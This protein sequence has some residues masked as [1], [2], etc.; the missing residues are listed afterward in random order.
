MVEV[1]RI[2]VDDLNIKLIQMMENA[3]R[4]LAQLVMALQNPRT[5][6]VYVG[7]GGNGGGALVAARH[8]ANMGVDV[9]VV[10]ARDPDDFTAVP[11]HQLDVVE[12]MGLP[13]GSEPVRCDVALDG[14]IGYSLTGPPRGSTSEFI[15]HL[16]Q[17]D[18]PV[19]S[20]DVPSG[21]D[22]STGQAPGQVVAANATLTLAAPKDG[23]RRNPNVGRLFVA[24]I[25]V[26][27]AVYERFALAGSAPPFEL[28]SI[29]EVV[30][31]HH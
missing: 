29:L 7:T 14:L 11:K 23:L 4:S 18:A 20:L 17:D 26:P 1:D 31:E 13:V 24:D 6:G 16:V 5:A 22:V 12:R 9:R 30:E 10:T 27:P 2:M 15:D 8:L 28:G 19:V 25:S 21:L 3:G